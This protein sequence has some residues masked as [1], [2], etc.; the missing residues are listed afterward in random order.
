M[1]GRDDKL[2]DDTTVGLKS[3]VEKTITDREQ[4]GGDKYKDAH[5]N[6]EDVTAAPPPDKYA[7]PDDVN[8]SAQ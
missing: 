2:I 7:L 3:P 5:D 8:A 4:E 1:I 6:M